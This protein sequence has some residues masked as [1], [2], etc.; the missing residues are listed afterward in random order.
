MGYEKAGRLGAL[1][2]SHVIQKIGA[3]P[4]VPLKELA[5]QVGVL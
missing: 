4:A 2:A 3:R 1:A 5:E